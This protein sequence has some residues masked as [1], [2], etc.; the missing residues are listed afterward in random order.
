[1]GGKEAEALKSRG[2]FWWLLVLLIGALVVITAVLTILRDI[3]YLKKNRAPTHPINKN[4]ADALE[5]A[6]QFFDIQKCI[7]L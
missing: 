6:L 3:H 4:Y 5:I 2:L 1:M 7:H